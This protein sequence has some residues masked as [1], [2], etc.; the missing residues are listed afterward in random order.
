MLAISLQ[1]TFVAHSDREG[2]VVLQ[3]TTKL[4]RLG[5]VSETRGVIVLESPSFWQTG[6]RNKTVGEAQRRFIAQE[7]VLSPW[8]QHKTGNIRR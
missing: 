5:I 2:G 3:K 1:K 8:M 7:K 6:D 4:R